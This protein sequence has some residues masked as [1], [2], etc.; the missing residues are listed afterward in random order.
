MFLDALRRAGSVEVFEPPRPSR[1]RRRLAEA[2]RRPRSAIPGTEP[3]GAARR[4]FQRTRPGGFDLVWFAEVYSYAAFAGDV[5]GRAGIDIARL[6]SMVV[7]R[8]LRLCGAS[9]TVPDL[10]RRRAQ[11]LELEER[12]VE[13][14]DVITVCNDID[15]AQL[16]S[17]A[18]EVVPTGYPDP[19]RHRT[20]VGLHTPPVL[21]TQGTLDLEQNAD[22]ARYAVRE[23]VPLVRQSVPDV[24]LRVVG[25]GP[26]AVLDDLAGVPG[27]VA[28]GYVEDMGAELA[29]ADVAIAPI[30]HG[31]GIHVKVIEAFAHQ[32][33]VVTTPIGTEGVDPEPWYEALVAQSAAEFADRCI[34][35]LRSEELRHRVATGGRKLY[36]RRFELGAVEQ[37]VAAIAQGAVAASL[38]Q[39]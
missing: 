27:V 35:L 26:A 13:H 6:E 15:A 11:W 9:A 29:G 18:C 31:G 36:L 34:E 14:A 24:E 33:P 25:P 22:A 20:E 21:V 28:T 37:R 30:R 12:I 2:W 39:P 32:L 23:I 1:A 38:H 3:S 4:A 8:E 5:P 10:E 19:Q 16:G 7:E 17:P